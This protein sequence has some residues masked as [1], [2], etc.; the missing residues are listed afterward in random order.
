MTTRKW[1]TGMRAFG[2]L[3]YFASRTIWDLFLDFHL[4]DLAAKP[5]EEK[6]YTGAI[7]GGVIGGVV[8]IIIVVVGVWYCSKKKKERTGRV[9]PESPPEEQA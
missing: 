5:A 9:S 7:V 3:K 4:V 2:Y 1:P 8:L 6:D